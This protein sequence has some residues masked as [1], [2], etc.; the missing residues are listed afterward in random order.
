VSL[1]H[2][3]PSYFYKLVGVAAAVLV[4]LLLGYLSHERNSVEGSTE[5]GTVL[6]AKRLI[7]KGTSGSSIAAQNLFVVVTVPKVQIA[8]KAI[9]DPAVL[10]GRIAA[11]DIYPRQQLAASDFTTPH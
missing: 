11:G 7:P 1:H 9:S 3:F 10:Q 6:V 5:R 4:G 2:R 8:P